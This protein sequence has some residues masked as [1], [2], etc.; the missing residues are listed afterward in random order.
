[1]T[2]QTIDA[3]K[4]DPH[5]YALKLRHDT[6][7]HRFLLN[8][9]DVGLHFEGSFIASVMTKGTIFSAETNFAVC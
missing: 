3:K 7:I 1:M 9:K 4:V 2:A 6:E 5:G 8:T